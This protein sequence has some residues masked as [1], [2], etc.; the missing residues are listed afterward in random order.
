ML[1]LSTF[2]LLAL[3][4]LILCVE[5]FYDI[6]GISK[7]ASERDIKKAYRTLSKRYHPDKNPND[8]TAKQKFV[9]IADA[10]DALSDPTSRSIYDKYGHDGLAQHRQQSAGG[11]GRQQHDPFDLFSRF[12]GG[13]GH[14]GHSAS[15]RR[16]PDMEV[17]VSVP[18]RDFYA[19]A[20]HEFSIEK[21]QICEECE[22]SGSADGHVETCSVCGGQGRV[23]RKQQL[24]PG[25]FTQV[26]MQCERCGGKGKTIRKPCK[27][28]G[29]SKVVRKASSFTLSV[30][31]GMPKNAKVVY[32]NEG[33]ESPDWVAGDLVVV[34][35]EKGA[36]MGASD[37]ERV[38]GAFMRRK[39][40]ELFWK[41]V[42]SLREAWMGGWTRNL[43]HLDGHV[44][45][46][47]RE[48][49]KV[50]QPGSVEVVAGEGM[51]TW[52]NERDETEEDFGRLHVEYT[53]VLPD[54]MEKPMEKE[55]WAL[56]EKW[57]RK[58]GVD[59]EKEM[60]RP[61]VKIK[62]EL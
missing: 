49:G 12:F 19:G 47:G 34:I 51:P 28:C 50:V 25:M 7:S 33:D 52:M 46:L 35:G 36:E 54:Q 29:G 58:N 16:G 59:L 20:E 14:F 43:T 60:G 1:F 44:V 15:Q 8:E 62:D 6:L 38:D 21:Q 39:G 17:R 9:S 37:E 31:K 41:E 53:V 11:G 2:L 56:W 30:E 57:R 55:F 18:L 45:H 24:A 3:L 22:G 32:E 26:Q 27:V 23:V 40:R 42:L 5:D 10:Y 61:E 13:G 4:P 48:R